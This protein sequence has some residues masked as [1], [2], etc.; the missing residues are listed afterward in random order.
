M[1]ISKIVSVFP[2]KSRFLT[3]NLDKENVVGTVVG[4]IEQWELSQTSCQIV[5]YNWPHDHF[6]RF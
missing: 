3:L 5:A 4:R 2:K 6:A 1:L